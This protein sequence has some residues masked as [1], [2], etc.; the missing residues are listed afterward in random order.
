[1]I[2]FE[3][4]IILVLEFNGDLRC[5]NFFSENDPVG[6]IIFAIGKRLTWTSRNFMVGTNS[7]VVYFMGFS[8]TTGN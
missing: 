2:L 5:R 6:T 3:L 7:V 8:M 1:M 4:I